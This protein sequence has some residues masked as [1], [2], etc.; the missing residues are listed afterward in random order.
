M[1]DGAQEEKLQEMNEQI[2]ALGISMQNQQDLFEQFLRGLD[3]KYLE[4][5]T[6]SPRDIAEQNE[7]I[8]AAIARIKSTKT[9]VQ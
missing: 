2:R 8:M 3:A 5:R 1:R 4:D 9:T 7:A 6:L